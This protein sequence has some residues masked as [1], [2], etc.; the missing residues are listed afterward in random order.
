MSS[1]IELKIDGEGVSPETVSWADLREIV[2]GMHAAILATASEAGVPKAKVRF[3]LVDITEG[4]D[5]L[6]FATDKG[7][8]RSA[9]RIVSAIQS[10]DESGL[11]SE[12]IE[13]VQR[14]WKRLH[15]NHWSLQ[16]ARNG[17]ESTRATIVPELQPFDPPER[18]IGGKTKLLVQVIR[19]GGESPTARV[20]VAGGKAFTANIVNRNVASQLATKLYHTIQVSADVTWDLDRNEILRAKI[21]GVEPYDLGEAKPLEALQRL[22]ELSQGFWDTINPTDFMNDIRS[23]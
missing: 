22:G 5:T 15:K 8:H 10:R 23:N 20:Q 16:V 3:S 6:T 21:T 7:T 12:A 17:K 11:N 9:Q 2:S 14:A 13:G 18:A 4:S 19:V 1:H